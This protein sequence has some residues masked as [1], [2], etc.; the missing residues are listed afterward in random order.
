MTKIFETLKDNQTIAKISALTKSMGKNAAVQL[1]EFFLR[2]AKGSE[3]TRISLL[4]LLKDS[5]ISPEKLKEIIEKSLAN[6][7]NC[8]NP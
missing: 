2:L 8:V 5:K 7:K 1:D 4:E 3:N 6:A